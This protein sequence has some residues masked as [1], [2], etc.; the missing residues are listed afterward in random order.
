MIRY[1][2]SKIMEDPEVESEVM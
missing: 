2:M 1:H